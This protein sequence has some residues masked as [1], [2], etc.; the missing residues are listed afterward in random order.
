MKKDFSY[1]V[2][3]GIAKR[4]EYKFL[5]I[6]SAG[7]DGYWGFPKGHKETGENNIAAARR[8]LFEET[9]INKITII[10][11]QTFED[12][13]IYNREGI[14]QDRLVT[15]YLGLVD[16]EPTLVLQ[17]EEIQDAK[18]LDFDS[19]HKLLSFETLKKIIVKAK[20]YL[21]SRTN[22]KGTSDR[23]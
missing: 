21:D 3:P 13:F 4:Q 11:T 5:L 6:C 1:G 22:D 16:R 9:G 10:E 19:A 23:S 20:D 12:K 17:D 14:D 15:F 8:E 18:W 7:E 2:I